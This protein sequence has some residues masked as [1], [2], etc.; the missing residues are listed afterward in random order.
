MSKT[1]SAQECNWTTAE[2]EECWAIVYAFKKFQYLIP[3]IHF[4]L[5]TDHKNLIYID[6]ET[7]QK[8]KRWKLAIQEY[9]FDIQHIPG[10][11]NVIADAVFRLKDIPEEFVHWMDEDDAQTKVDAFKLSRGMAKLLNLNIETVLWLEGYQISE[12]AE[13]DI[14]RHHNDVVGH[15]GIQRTIGCLI[16][17]LELHNAISTTRTLLWTLLRGVLTGVPIES[18]P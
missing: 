1:L 8:V 15:D 11:L 10:R 5:L 9:D 17:E 14:S 18:L 7:S 13:Y 2:K 4:T 6:S 16:R 3:D 12:E